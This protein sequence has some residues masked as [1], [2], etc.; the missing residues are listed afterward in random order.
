MFVIYYWD[1]IENSLLA[2]VDDESLAKD[3]TRACRPRHVFYA[4]T[5]D[6]FVQ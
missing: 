6:W 5:R 2:Y 4:A 1:G 3:I